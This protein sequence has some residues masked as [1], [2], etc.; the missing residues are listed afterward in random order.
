MTTPTTPI[1]LSAL[2]WTGLTPAQS[3]LLISAARERDG[4]RVQVDAAEADCDMLR[5]QLTDVIALLDEA[6]AASAKEPESDYFRAQLVSII[7]ERDRAVEALEPFGFLQYP[8]LVSE[9][10]D[11]GRMHKLLICESQIRDARAA[12]TSIREAN[13]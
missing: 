10:E 6:C 2:V 7:A 8:T 13:K 5:A 11:D 4:L 9:I 12:L 3:D 1:D